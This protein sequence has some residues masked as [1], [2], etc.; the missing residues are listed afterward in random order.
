MGGE[1]WPAGTTA[2]LRMPHL[3][4][5]VRLGATA[6]AAASV[7]GGRVGG[8]HLRRHGLRHRNCSV[9]T[10]YVALGAAGAAVVRG[11]VREFA[12]AV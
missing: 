2:L 7:V 8:M 10:I 3:L 5:R 11:S 1:H 6:A 9:K 4:L 12:L